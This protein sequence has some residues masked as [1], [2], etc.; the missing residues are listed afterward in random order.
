MTP[1]IE[2]RDLVREYRMG[3]EQVH[4]LRGVSFTVDE[5]EY[6]AIVGPSGCGKSTLLNLLGVIDRPTSGTVSIAGERVDQLSDARATDFR[7]RRIGFVFQRFYLMQ[8]LTA[9][10]NIELPLA[11]AGMKGAARR[12]RARALLDYVGLGRREGH[13]PSQLS[14]GE[15]QRVAIARALANEPKLLLADEPTGELDARTGAEMIALFQRLNGDGTTIVVVTHDED[16]ARAAQARDPHARRL[17]RRRRACTKGCTMIRLLAFRNLTLNPWRSVFLLFGFSMGVAV[18]IVLLS[19]GEALLDQAKDEKLVGGGS[20]TVLPEGVDV[21]VMKTGGL[22]GLF[23]SIDHARF[24]HRAAP[25]GAA[26]ARR[27]VRGGAAGRGQAAV[28]PHRGRRASAPCARRVTFRRSPRP[29]VRDPTSHRDSGATI[30]STAAGARRRDAELR[31]D[32]DHFHL[33]PREVAG[34]PSWGEW[35]YFNVIS[36]DRQ[37]WAFVSF[38]VAGA[39][40]G[41]ADRWGGQ[42]L[43]TLHEQGKPERR[44]TSNVPS[45]LVHYSTT[46]ADLAIGDSRVEVQPDGRYL[47]RAR[48]REDGRGTPLTIDLVVSPAAGAYFPGAALTSGVVSGYVVPALRAD[49]SGSL[50]VGGACTTYDAVQAYHDHN[51]GVWRGV[52]WEWGAARAGEYTLLYG[53][54]EPPD[55]VSAAQPLF[56]Y[57]VDSRGIPRRVSTARHSV[58]G[59]ANDDRERSVHPH[60]GDA[61][62]WWTCAAPIR[63]DS[64]STSRTPARA[65]RARRSSNGATRSAH[66]SFPV[67]TSCR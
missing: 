66:A 50:C 29:S 17:H 51:W 12:D 57:L 42:V 63:C 13:R 2:V 23:F 8:A 41:A 43:V 52:T 19:I 45:P 48:A 20:I 30:R 15:Q 31:H 7:L 62:R 61:R 65:T 53:R 67:R 32:I 3:A 38:I 9:R 33:P 10:E 54:I 58:R 37:R 27:R 5:G 39:V 28:S 26:A 24:I 60:A 59:R 56:V 49:A 4:A 35:H 6:A 1:T 18:M 44:F 25:R 16:L 47:V 55:S 64:V 46:S 22:G 34:D 14:G 40:G 11:E 36:P 21:E